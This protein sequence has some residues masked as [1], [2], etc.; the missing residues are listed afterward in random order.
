[1]KQKF[2][3]TRLQFFP[4]KIVVW[5][6]GLAIHSGEKSFHNR[7]C[8][9]MSLKQ[10]RVMHKTYGMKSAAVTTNTAGFKKSDKN[11]FELKK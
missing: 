3:S 5:K 1:M 4:V 7:V 9:W 6:Y 11:Y 2:E 8:N 10:K